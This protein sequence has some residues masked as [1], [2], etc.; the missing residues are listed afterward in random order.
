MSKHNYNR[1]TAALYKWCPVWFLHTVFALIKRKVNK[2]D[3]T[4][5]LEIVL[6]KSSLL[7]AI[8]LSCWFEKQVDVTT[9]KLVGVC[10]L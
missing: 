1:G 2:F 3:L 10:Q 4:I 9:E 5:V 7:K 8:Y 6:F